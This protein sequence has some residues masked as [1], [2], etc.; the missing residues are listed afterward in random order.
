MSSSELLQRHVAE[1]NAKVEAA[2]RRLAEKE[3]TR[4]ELAAAFE[5]H[6]RDIKA[7]HR[8]IMTRVDGLIAADRH[9]ADELGPPIDMLEAPPPSN[10]RILGF[11]QALRG[12]EQ[13]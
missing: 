11:N 4:S 12:A 8:S 7:F 10:A 5:Q 13:P 6:E 2:R 1:H 3:Q 9:E